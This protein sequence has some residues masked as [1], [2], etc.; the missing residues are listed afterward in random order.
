[1]PMF[2]FFWYVMTRIEKDNSLQKTYTF[3]D[4]V[5]ALSWMIQCSFV[6][7]HLGHHPEWT[8]IYNK[9]FVTLKTHDA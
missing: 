5:S 1:M 7:E 4:F 6:I 9:V 3:P 8:N 2:Y